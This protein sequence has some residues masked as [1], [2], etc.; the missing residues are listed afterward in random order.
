MQ[1]IEP[2]FSCGH[3]FLPVV[4]KYIEY[5]EFSIL[6][7]RNLAALLFLSHSFTKEE[8]VSTCEFPLSS[9]LCSILC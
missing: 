4:S 8:G 3:I 6:N 5:E 2:I 1:S 7:V 9:S